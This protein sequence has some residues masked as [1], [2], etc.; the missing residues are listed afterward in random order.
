[1]HLRITELLR[2]TFFVWIYSLPSRRGELIS[3]RNCAKTLTAW[4]KMTAFTMPMT[5]KCLCSCGSGFRPISVMLT[6]CKC[7]SIL[8]EDL[9]TY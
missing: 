5:L 6:S 3:C 9:L 2:Y 8:N 7:C 1:V 4:C